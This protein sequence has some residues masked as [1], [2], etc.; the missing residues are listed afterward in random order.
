MQRYLAA[1]VERDFYPESHA[2]T[3]GR[4]VIDMNPE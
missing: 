3:A 4:E 1:R 2:Y